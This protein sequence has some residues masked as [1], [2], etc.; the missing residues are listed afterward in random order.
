MDT[1]L[2]AIAIGLFILITNVLDKKKEKA[3]RP[4]QRTEFPGVPPIP[5][6]QQPQV[7]PPMPKPWPQTRQGQTAESRRSGGKIDFEIPEIRQNPTRAEEKVYREP[8]AVLQERA[9]AY[10]RERTA[11]NKYAAY[12]EQRKN[13]EAAERAME[14]AVYAQQAQLPGQAKRER[15]PID[16]RPQAMTQAVA[17][18]MLLGKPKAYENMRRYGGFR[19]T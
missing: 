2:T 8:G 7:P 19:R 9:A 10:A 1:I 4:P 16:T 18:A 11:E 14:K 15:P 12:L 17:Y 13:D 6:R 5:R 3:K